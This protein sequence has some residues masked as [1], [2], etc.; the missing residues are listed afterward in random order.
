MTSII[1]TKLLYMIEASTRLVLCSSSDSLM[2]N[3][4]PSSLPVTTQID[5][6]ADDKEIKKAYRKLAV[7]HHPDKGGDERK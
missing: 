5:K 6:D 2:T 4:L 7:K 1:Q 3:Y